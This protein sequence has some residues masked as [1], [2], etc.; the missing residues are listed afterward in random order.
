MN[1]F[2]GLIY[3]VGLMALAVAGVLLLMCFV[4]LLAACMRSS[5]LSQ[6]EE[7]RERHPVHLETLLDNSCGE[8]GELPEQRT[9]DNCISSDTPA[10]DA[11]ECWECIKAKTRYGTTPNWHKKEAV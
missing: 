1:A 6:Q 11:P 2:T 7:Q 10:L 8:L 5:Q 4:G 9:C 3:L